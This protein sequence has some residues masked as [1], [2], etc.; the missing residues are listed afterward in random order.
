MHFLANPHHNW[1]DWFENAWWQLW[2]RASLFADCLC[3]G[4]SHCPGQRGCA[5]LNVHPAIQ[6]Q[7]GFIHP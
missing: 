2:P 6:A 3:L 4:M 7:P 5:L 1:L